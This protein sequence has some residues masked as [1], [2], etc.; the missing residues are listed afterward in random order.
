MLCQTLRVRG[1]TRS[2]LIQFS[3]GAPYD[4][5]SLGVYGAQ[6]YTA[7]CNI[8]HKTR[9]SDPALS[10][11]YTFLYKILPGR[12]SVRHLHGQKP[13]ARG[14]WQVW[15][16][17]NKAYRGG[18]Q[19]IMGLGCSLRGQLRMRITNS[20]G[21]YDDSTHSRTH[22]HAPLVC[23]QRLFESHLSSLE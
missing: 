14:R 9:P 18:M 23:N 6:S 21:Y 13:N 16:A 15:E 20:N 1:S 10:F 11:H 12:A 2:H 5:A 17:G 7:N 4:M 19:C 22:I 8:M 3:H